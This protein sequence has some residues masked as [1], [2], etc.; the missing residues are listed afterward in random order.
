MAVT[1]TKEVS[2]LLTDVRTNKV[3]ATLDHRGFPHAEGGV[4]LLAGEQGTVLYL[5]LFESSAT[6]KNLVRSIWFDNRVAIALTGTEG[7]SF[8]I[9]G[10]PVKVHI[11]GPLFLKYY[12]LLRQDQENLNLAAVWEIEPD[13]IINNSQ[14]VRRENEEQAHP[15]FT[16]LDRLAR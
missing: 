8:Q 13:E 14:A 4:S 5:E 2:D 3:L 12:Q 1:L 6:N 7:E 16:H 15:F 11:T 9:K 10:K